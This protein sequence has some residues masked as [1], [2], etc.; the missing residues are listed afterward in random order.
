[1]TNTS[2]PLL[3]ALAVTKLKLLKCENFCTA[4]WVITSASRT[5]SIAQNPVGPP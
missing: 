3:R 4:S 1:M 5:P 2:P